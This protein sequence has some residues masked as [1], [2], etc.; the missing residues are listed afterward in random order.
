MVATAREALGDDDRVELRVCDLLDLEVVE[1]VD[2]I[3]SNATF[4]WILDHRLLFARL[5]A[6]LKPGGQMEAE[7]GGEGNVAEWKREIEAAEG[8]ERFSAYLRTMPATHN[9][10]SL[11]DTRSRLERAGFELERIW[12]ERRTVRPDDP[13]G[14]VRAVS[15]AKHLAQLPD[16]LHE[17]FIDAVSDRCRARSCSSTC[18]ST[19]RLESRDEWP[20]CWRCSRATESAR[21]WSPWRDGYSIRSAASSS[22]SIWSAEHRSMPMAWR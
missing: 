9:F 17:Q 19:S 1:P 14:Y 21:R 2:A 8:D 20:C 4:H 13:R 7:F 22:A 12:L 10:A 3:F 6:A 5:F 11:G 15:L 16:E 18:G